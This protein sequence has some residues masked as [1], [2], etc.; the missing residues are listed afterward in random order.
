[1]KDTVWGSAGNVLLEF[2]VFVKNVAQ[3][4]FGISQLLMVVLPNVEVSSELSSSLKFSVT[5]WVSIISHLYSFPCPVKLLVWPK[6][7]L[8]SLQTVGTEIVLLQQFKN[9][10]LVKSMGVYFEIYQ[11]ALS[12]YLL[13]SSGNKQINKP[14]SHNHL[15]WVTIDSNFFLS[16]LK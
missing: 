10:K 1:M 6:S 2:E 3:L 8:K 4:T 14:S 7:Y 13:F 16:S 9:S 11:L 12:W 5:T 15:I